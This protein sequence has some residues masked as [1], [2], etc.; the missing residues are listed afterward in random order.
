MTFDDFFTRIALIAT[1]LPIALAQDCIAN[2]TYETD[3][4]NGL[5]VVRSQAD[6]DHLV[7]CTSV[8]GPI[9]IHQNYTGPFTLNGVANYNGS[10]YMDDLRFPLKM[11]SFEMLDVVTFNGFISLH[12]VPDVRLPKLQRIGSA[13]LTS[14]VE[15][16]IDAD[17][18]VDV[19]T[20]RL[21]GPWTS[22]KMGS[23]R[24]ISSTLHVCSNIDCDMEGEGWVTGRD[25]LL[26][27]QAFVNFPSLE[28]AP[29]IGINGSITT[30]SLPR[31]RTVGVTDDPTGYGEGFDLVVRNHQ[32]ELNLP[33]L[34][35][36]ALQFL[37]MGSISRINMSALRSTE[38]PIYIMTDMDADISLPVLGQADT[39]DIHGRIKSID[40]PQ[41]ARA[42]T[43][44]ITSSLTIP[45]T[46]S[47][48]RLYRD[49]TLTN[50]D[51]TWCG[52]QPTPTPTP[53]SR[54]RPSPTPDGRSGI[55]LP[56][57]TVA[58]IAAGCVVGGLAVIGAVIWE[59]KR[60]KNIKKF[61]NPQGPRRLSVVVENVNGR[62]GAGHGGSHAATPVAR[63]TDGSGRRTE[64]EQEP[65]D[66][67]PPPYTR[68]PG[69]RESTVMEVVR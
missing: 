67:P 37:T 28:W 8:T 61:R 55:H 36:V 22:V 51:P 3:P 19:K 30:I 24:N 68:E 43:I 56:E 49:Q 13:S 20:L 40:V 53:T 23:L 65:K 42:S 27:T 60:R 4:F 45:C 64:V 26:D 41:L 5:L 63:I 31:L 47:L 2:A 69:E 18:L 54:S 34:E 10:I 11:S 57:S 25:I 32:L 52:Q 12:E 9:Q 62:S 1:L 17:V 21:E 29:Y 48:R 15:G 35:T 58:A 66:V 38:A 39:L 46:D 50:D 14:S 44:D 7:G 16:E 33:A 6:I 59:I